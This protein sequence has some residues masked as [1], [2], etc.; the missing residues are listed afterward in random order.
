VSGLITR[1]GG[2][3]FPMGMPQGI[4][5]PLPPLP[6]LVPSGMQPQGLNLGSDR[7]NRPGRRGR[8]RTRRKGY[9]A[10]VATRP[11]ATRVPLT[12]AALIAG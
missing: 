9:W 8:T 4:I 7:R 5:P 10:V 1:P 3:L 2:L 6:N 11:A 12:T